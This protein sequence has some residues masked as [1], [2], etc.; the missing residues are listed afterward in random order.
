MSAPCPVTPEQLDGILDA[1][2]LIEAVTEGNNRNRE[3]I[4]AEARLDT[5]VAGLVVVGSHL[6]HTLAVN[7]GIT[8]AAVDEL[9]RGMYLGTGQPL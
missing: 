8:P 1:L 5:L 4:M 9:L 3:A 7:T 2:A 6:R